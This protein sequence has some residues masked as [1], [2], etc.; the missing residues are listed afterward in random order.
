MIEVC[1]YE[2]LAESDVE[3][4]LDKELEGIP[5]KELPDRK[6]DEHPGVPDQKRPKRTAADV[7]KATVA[8]EDL[9]ARIDALEVLK[10]KMAAE[11]DI[12]DEEDERLAKSKAISYRFQI[13]S[14]KKTYP[15]TEEDPTDEDE[16][17]FEVEPD[18]DEEEEEGNEGEDERPAK[19]RRKTKAKKGETRRAVETEK[20]QLRAAGKGGKAEAVVVRKKGKELTGPSLSITPRPTQLS[21]I[22]PAWLSKSRQKL[23]TS[24]AP[25]PPQAD[26]SSSTLGG[27]GDDDAFS[28]GPMYIQVL[29]TSSPEPAPTPIR[30]RAGTTK[31]PEGVKQER[32]NSSLTPTSST[33]IEMPE[34]IRDKWLSIVLPSLYDCFFASDNPFT[35]FT[36]GSSDL[37]RKIQGVLDVTILGHQY[38]VFRGSKIVESTYDRINE[39]RSLFSTRAIEAIDNFFKGPEYLDNPRAIAVYANWACIV[40]EGTAG[41]IC[42]YGLFESQFIVNAAAGLLQGMKGSVGGFGPPQGAIG[43]AAAA[44]ERGFMMYLTGTRTAFEGADR[45][46]SRE[47]V[48]SLVGD[49]ISNTKK[50]SKNAW[51]RIELACSISGIRG[52]ENEEI[53]GFAGA[54]SLEKKR[55]ALFIPSSPAASDSGD[56]YADQ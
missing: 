29:D 9:Q 19:K 41:Y 4:Q 10:R 31:M 18:M 25:L 32:A 34:F 53:K 36:K 51:G 1:H 46:F 13:Q 17:F 15:V 48:G 21:G 28:S 22:Q 20:A 52:A 43:L 47:C 12:Q 26:F 40:E 24:M 27:L 38:R 6:Q 50:L 30:R 44:V 23:P 55:R 54:P 3:M 16:P 37:I 11:R 8:Y 5:K 7:E 33:E 2:K 14:K 49:Y 39:K 42:P 35:P 45:K 56:I